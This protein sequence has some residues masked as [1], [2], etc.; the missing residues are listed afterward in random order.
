M[1]LKL[2]EA[3]SSDMSLVFGCF[4]DLGESQ[5]DETML[6]RWVKTVIEIMVSK[7]P[8]GGQPPISPFPAIFCQQF[9]YLEKYTLCLLYNQERMSYNR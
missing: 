6:A 9:V 7:P 1:G 3:S 2:K 8:A 4:Q 5:I